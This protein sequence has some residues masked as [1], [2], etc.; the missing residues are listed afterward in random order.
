MVSR[1]AVKRQGKN[2]RKARTTPDRR[3]SETLLGID[4]RSPDR[5]VGGVVQVECNVNI[6]ELKK[7]KSHGIRES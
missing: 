2:G 3:R 5:G 1:C 7:G 6:V 4:L